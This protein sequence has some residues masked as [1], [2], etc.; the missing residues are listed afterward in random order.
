MD[1]NI[2]KAKNLTEAVDLLRKA[3]PH[4][5]VIIAKENLKSLPE[6]FKKLL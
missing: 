2:K 3:G 4:T 5:P 6:S 1:N